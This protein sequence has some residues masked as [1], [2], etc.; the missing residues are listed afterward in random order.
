MAYV[1]MVVPGSGMTGKEAVRLHAEMKRQRDKEQKQEIIERH[2]FE[3]LGLDYSAVQQARAAAAA[4]Q[5]ARAA[6]NRRIPYQLSLPGVNATLMSLRSREPVHPAD[7]AAAG[8]VGPMG[9]QRVPAP[10]GRQL[11]LDFSGPMNGIRRV[12]PS[13]AGTTAVI[14]AEPKRM[15]GHKLME[16]LVLASMA[17]GAGTG[18]VIEAYDQDGS[19]F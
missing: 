17:G 10:V 18:A 14:S 6:E 8:I 1:S 11:E 3:S 12:V 9:W 5:L 4:D 7:A 15:A 19:Q 16:M 2:H 13:T